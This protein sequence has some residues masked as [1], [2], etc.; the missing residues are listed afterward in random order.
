MLNLKMQ[1]SFSTTVAPTNGNYKHKQKNKIVLCAI[2]RERHTLLTRRQKFY[3]A[4]LASH[5]CTVGNAMQLLLDG[6]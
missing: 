6:R 5:T 4:L 3:E 1:I 2:E